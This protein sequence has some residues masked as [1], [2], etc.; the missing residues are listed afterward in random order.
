MKILNKTFFVL[1]IALSGSIYSA[2]AQIYVTVHPNRPTYVRTEAPSRRHV[3]ID[4]DWQERNGKYEWSGGHWAEPPQEGFR[5][6][7][8]HWEHTNHGD[9]WVPGHWRR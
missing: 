9:R 4:E 7:E 8:G 3:W 2:S 5:Y 1:A 6:K